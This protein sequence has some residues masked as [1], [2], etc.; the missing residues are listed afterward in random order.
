MPLATEVIEQVTDGR[1]A[2]FILV[3][4]KVVTN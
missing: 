4:V 3:E 2:L 1:D